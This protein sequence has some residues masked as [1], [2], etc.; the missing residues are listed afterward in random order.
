MFFPPDLGPRFMEIIKPIWDSPHP[1]S[2][3]LQLI[4]SM[5]TGLQGM[6]LGHILVSR[7][8]DG[9]FAGPFRGMRLVPDI[10][11]RHFSPVLLG[12]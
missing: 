5:L 4:W 9:V 12:T 7:I 2:V 3:K 8:G 6:V 10:M 11:N 1:D